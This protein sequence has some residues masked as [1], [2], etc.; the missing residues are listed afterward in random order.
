MGSVRPKIENSRYLSHFGFLLLDQPGQP[1]QYKID[2][3]RDQPTPN[4][5]KSRLKCIRPSPLP[6]LPQNLL[7]GGGSFPSPPIDF[8]H[9]FLSSKLLA[10]ASLSFS[11]SN[12]TNQDNFL[13]HLLANSSK[14]LP[15][16]S[17]TS[18][19]TSGTAAIWRT[20]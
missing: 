6:G 2:F 5:P 14:L 20:A 9:I 15:W 17:F 8:S 16:L 11:L 7:N 4:N 1:E 12:K 13:T 18:R 3:L 19:Q 10:N